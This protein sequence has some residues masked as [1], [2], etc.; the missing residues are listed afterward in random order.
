M[1]VRRQNEDPHYQQPAVFREISQE[2]IFLMCKFL[3]ITNLISNYNKNDIILGLN[4]C[5]I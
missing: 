5:L 2:I 3:L 4:A 1:G